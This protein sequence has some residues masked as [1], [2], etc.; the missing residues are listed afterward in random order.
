MDCNLKGIFQDSK[1]NLKQI[2]SEA[3]EMGNFNDATS[4]TTEKP[5]L[6]S[7]TASLTTIDKTATAEKPIP[8][9]AILTR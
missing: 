6:S 3:K 8:W 7:T 2:E 5:T 9:K 4:T 1:D